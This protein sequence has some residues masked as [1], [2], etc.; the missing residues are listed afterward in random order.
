MPQNHFHYQS[1]AF[2]LALS[3]ILSLATGAAW[4]KADLS[5]PP[6]APVRVV[7]DEYFG[8][9]VADPY[10]YMED[11]TNPEVAA[12]FKGEND[13]TRAVLERIPGRTALLARIK[14]LDE[15]A[16]ARVSDLRRLPGDCVGRRSKS[17]QAAVT[18]RASSRRPTA[19]C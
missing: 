5:A 10:R 3:A 6:V 16:P 13:Y 12:W 9:K 19:R 14:T 2:L 1:V 15:G 11:L 4:N 17:L 8:V 18:D 7:T